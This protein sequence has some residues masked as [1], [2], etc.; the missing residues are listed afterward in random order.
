MLRIFGILVIIA[1][2]GLWIGNVSGGFRTF[3]GLGYL[4][5]L[6]GGSMAKAGNG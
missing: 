5:I 6:I 4:T 2:I 1:G 3:P